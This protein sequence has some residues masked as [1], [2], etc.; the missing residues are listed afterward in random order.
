PRR[1]PLHPARRVRARPRVEPPRRLRPGHPP[2]PGLEP[3][4]PRAARGAGGV[5]GGVPPLPRGRPARHHLDARPRPRPARGAGRD[6]G[7]RLMTTAAVRVDPTFLL[8]V[9]GVTELVLVRHAKQTVSETYLAQ[10]VGD[11][12]DPP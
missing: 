4:P 2:L 5:G 9:G 12:H 3:G 8:G 11:L 10:K 1:R 7:G 6:P